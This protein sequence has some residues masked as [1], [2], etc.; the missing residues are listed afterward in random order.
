MHDPRCHACF[1][2]NGLALASCDQRVARPDVHSDMN[3]QAVK[4]FQDDTGFGPELFEDNTD[5]LS[6]II[7]YH[8]LPDVVSP[9]D[10]NQLTDGYTTAALLHSGLPGSDTTITISARK[11]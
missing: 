2:G 3:L 7:L 4:S 5:V 11:T 9:K 1:R 10:V 8:T 6:Q